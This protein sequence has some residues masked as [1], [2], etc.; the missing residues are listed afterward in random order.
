M[1]ANQRRVIGAM[2]SMKKLRTHYDNLKVARD[3][4]PEIIRAAYKALSQ[5]Y[6]PDRNENSSESLR[7]MKIINESYE[8]LS[9]P[10]ARQK[11]DLWIR[12]QESQRDYEDRAEHVERSKTEIEFPPPVAGEVNFYDLDKASQQKI[13]A[14]ASGLNNNQYGIKL[15]GVIWNYIWITLLSGWFFY[16]YASAIEHRWDDETTYWHVGITAVV[17]FLLSRNIAWVCSWYSKPL[18]S[19]LIVTPLYLMRLHL[20]RMS[21]WPIWTI[22]D[23]KATH[24]Y[25]NGVYQNTL[26]NIKFGERTEGFSIRSEKA[27]DILLN[28][29]RDYDQKF[30]AAAKLNDLSYVIDNDELLFIRRNKVV[31][32]KRKPIASFVIYVLLLIL[33]FGFLGVS[34]DVNLSRPLKSEYSISR[35]PYNTEPK[36]EHVYVRPST[37]PNGAAWPKNS[38]YIEK[39]PKLNV[40]G[41]SSVTVDNSQNDSD[42]FVKLV[43][44]SAYE[45]R[46][47]RFFYIPAFGEFK[48]GNVKAG[49]YDIR[50]RDLTNGQL[51]RSESFTLEEVPTYN[52]T[53]FSE[54]TMTLYKVRNGNMQTYSLSE[55]EF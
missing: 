36:R 54:M 15:D 7:V 10:E 26:L 20:D 3:A 29:L 14:R 32:K 48:V 4:P 9:D 39:Y 38:S 17:W 42:V 30:R 6:H 18:K 11:H 46:P 47:V 52:G 55:S 50:Y 28:R 33:V 51:A 21:Y 40:G 1:G 49:I 35:T 25:R 24:N 12:Q 37:T 34:H 43:S 16:I 41:L 22:S 13:K 23:I 19:W 8:V 5:K 45:S 31:S 2:K 27:Y 53:R 44:I